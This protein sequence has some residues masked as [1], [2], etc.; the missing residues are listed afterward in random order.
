MTSP[1]PSTSVVIVSRGRPE[2]LIWCLSGIDGLIY[3]D[4]EVVV[5]ACPA[6]CAAVEA[7]GFAARLK[8]I[9]FDRANISAARNLGIAAAAGEVVAF[10]DDDAVPEPT[11]LEFLTEPFADAS[12][13]AVGGFVRGRNGISFQWTAREVDFSGRATPI[14]VDQSRFS[15]PR[16]A[17]DRA[18]KTE[19]TNMAVRRDTLARMGGFDEGFRFYLDETDLNLRLGKAGHKTAIAP[20]AQVHHAYAASDRRK[21]DRTVTDLSEIGAS[22]MYFLRRHAPESA[23]GE[24]LNE[25]MLEQKMRVFDQLRARKLQKRD[26]EPLLTGFRHGVDE[27]K[28]REFAK[29]EPVSEPNAPFLS[30]T[31]KR[32][33]SIVIAGRVWQ[34]ARLRREA[35]EHVAAGKTVSLFLFG[36]SPRYHTVKYA[37]GV[38]EQNGGVF[39]RSDRD[40]AIFQPQSFAKRVQREQARV[41]QLRGLPR[42]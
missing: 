13:T 12:V 5:V 9:G 18:I 39:G 4:F 2:S 10:I 30:F 33:D 1:S 25:V 22:V 23:H 36:P 32:H 34:A 19:G 6:G 42:E 11:W 8:L 24:R 31:P 28:T 26:V 20:L 14:E 3:P 38:W 27:G 21:A 15:L 17:P 37:E 16:P 7:A 40:G 41:T 29:L 35:K